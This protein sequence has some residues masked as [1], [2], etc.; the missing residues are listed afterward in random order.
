MMPKHILAVDDEPDILELLQY[1]FEKASFC[2]TCVKSGAEALAAVKSILPDLIVL[3]LMLPGMSG[4]EVCGILKGAPRTS[5]IPVVMLTARGSEMD[6]VRGLEAGADDYIVKPFS[7]PVLVARVKAVLRRRSRHGADEEGLLRV[8]DLVINA[9]RHEVLV[10][11]EPV[12]LTHTEFRILQFLARRPGWVFTRSQ[13]VDA[14]HGVGH[15]VTDRAVDV[16]IVGLRKK[17][18][19]S[20]DMIET[21]RGVGYRFK[22]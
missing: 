18:G 16:Q 14:V 19:D 5:G 10:R 6:V 4:F 22:E 20:S 2:C 7:P 11:N 1:S 21:V 8:H 9:A 15:P 3:D 17:L 12:D 13:V